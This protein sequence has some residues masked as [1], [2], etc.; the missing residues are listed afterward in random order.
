[1]DLH[2]DSLLIGRTKGHKALLQPAAKNQTIARIVNLVELW[3]AWA[4]TLGMVHDIAQLTLESTE[5]HTMAGVVGQEG[6]R[7]LNPRTSNGA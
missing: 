3:L 6:L 4:V 2:L 5:Q 7:L 1:M